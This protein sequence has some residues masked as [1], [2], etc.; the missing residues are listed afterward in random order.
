MCPWALWGP[1]KEGMEPHAPLG[2]EAN[3]GGRVK[4]SLLRV[5]KS[6]V[7]TASFPDK[8]CIYEATGE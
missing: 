5:H 1:M 2:P 8:F 6:F 4:T 3:T 7:Y